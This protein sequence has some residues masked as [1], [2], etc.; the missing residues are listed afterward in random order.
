MDPRHNAIIVYGQQIVDLVGLLA[1][2]VLTGAVNLVAGLR[3]DPG[4]VA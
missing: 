1:L 3:P 2:D 4:H